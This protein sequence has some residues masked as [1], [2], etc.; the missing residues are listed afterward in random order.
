MDAVDANELGRL[1]RLCFKNN[2]EKIPGSIIIP[3]KKCN[4]KFKKINKIKFAGSIIGPAM[5][6]PTGPFATALY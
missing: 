4:K 3:P 5:A 6:G 1:C 2:I